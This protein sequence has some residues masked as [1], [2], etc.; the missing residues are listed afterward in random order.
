[1]LCFPNLITLLLSIQHHLEQILLRS[2]VGK[3]IAFKV[4]NFNIKALSKIVGILEKYEGLLKSPLLHF[5]SCYL[6]I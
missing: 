2:H 5:S 4:H 3:L 6:L 1:M